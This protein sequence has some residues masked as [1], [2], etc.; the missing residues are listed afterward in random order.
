MRAIASVQGQTI[1]DWELICIDDGST[2]QSVSILHNAAALDDRICVVALEANTGPGMARNAGLDIAT[3][4]ILAFLDADDLWKPEKLEFQTKEMLG[5]KINFSFVPYENIRHGRAPKNMPFVER[6]GR[7]DLLK[8][9]VIGCSTVMLRSS[10]LN[11]QRFKSAPV[12]DL[13]F[14]YR[15]LGSTGTAFC[16]ANKAL[17]TR[18]QGL[19]S[20]N[21]KKAAFA[22]WKT[23]REYTGLT[24][25]QRLY[26]FT[27][28]A[29]N[30]S[31][32]YVG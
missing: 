28:Y 6:L 30:A 11:G 3:G 32:K 23:L 2:D 14:W 31:M 18:F 17:V 10:F 20:E 29:V 9:T 27:H 4:E 25:V 12:E 13:E 21:K 15:L 7:E 24:W 26:F 1:Q 22:Y 8:N 16:V 19:R 5:R